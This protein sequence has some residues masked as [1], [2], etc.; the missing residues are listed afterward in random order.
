MPHL[1]KAP[2]RWLQP[3]SPVMKLKIFISYLMIIAF[4][5][6]SCKKEEQQKDFPNETTTGANTFGCYV[7]NTQFL[8]CKTTGGISPVQKLQ[9][10][11]FE[12]DV[13]RPEIV[14]STVNDCEDNVHRSIA[15]A[16]DSVA[17]TPNTTYKLGDLSSVTRNKV[18]LTYDQEG[19]QFHSDSALNGSVTITFYDREKRILSGRFDATL[20][21]I[22]STKTVR[23]TQGRFDVKF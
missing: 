6:L 17:L 10:S 9:T 12:F 23:L 16:F 4:L 11:F 7:D 18:S 8:P 3:K 13:T 15:V 19:M 5:I 14:V 20:Q 2:L 1:H 21:D 22:N